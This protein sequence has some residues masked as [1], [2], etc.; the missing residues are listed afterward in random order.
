MR[1]ANARALT[2][3][4]LVEQYVTAIEWPST[5]AGDPVR[6]DAAKERLRS[7][8]KELKP[9]GEHEEAVKNG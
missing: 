6:L 9:T 5:I 4:A 7:Q 8:L 1:G 2:P 3:D